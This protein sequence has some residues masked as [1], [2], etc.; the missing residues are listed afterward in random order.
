MSK[1]E[2][3]GGVSALYDCIR[4]AYLFKE[5]AEITHGVHIHRACGQQRRVA[6]A[7]VH[8]TVITDGDGGYI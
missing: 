5:G 1:L 4:N 2:I 3:C 8:V 6:G 7:N